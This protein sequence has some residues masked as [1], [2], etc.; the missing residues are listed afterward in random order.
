M[1]QLTVILGPHRLPQASATTAGD[2]GAGGFLVTARNPFGAA[3]G[4]PGSLSPGGAADTDLAALF[5]GGGGLGEDDDDPFAALSRA[6][7]P[8][9]DDDARARAQGPPPTDARAGPPP[10]PPPPMSYVV[11]AGSRA[12]L[13]HLFG[14]NGGSLA[15]SRQGSEG[16]LSTVASVLPA[17]IRT[18]SRPLFGEPSPQA[19]QVRRL[20]ARVPHVLVFLRTCC[21]VGP[22]CALHRSPLGQG[23]GK[24]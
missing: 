3:G 22:E 19:S 13:A 15:G 7:P 1:P 5:G 10:E 23:T 6:A 21:C 18:A 17:A 12:D 14:A 2:L 24:V 20:P 8:P 4:T 11:A 9:E 16:A